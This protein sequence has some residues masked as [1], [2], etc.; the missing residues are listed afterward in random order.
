MGVRHCSA[1][2][3]QNNSRKHPKMH[4]FRFPKNEERCKKWIQNSRRAD[5]KGK[6]PSYCYGNL[7]LCETHFEASMFYNSLSK[8]SLL[9][10]AIPTLFDVPNPPPKLSLK[11][12]LPIRHDLTPQ[13]SKRDKN[14]FEMTLKYIQLRRQTSKVGRKPFYSKSKE[15][16]ILRRAMEAKKQAIR[17]LRRKQEKKKESSLSSAELVNEASKYLSGTEIAVLSY[18]LSRKKRSSNTFK[19]LALSL[20]YKSSSCYKLLSKRLQFPNPRTLNRWISHYKVREGFDLQLLNSLQVK[21]QSLPEENRVCTLL[22]DEMSLK[23]NSQYD[24]YVDKIVGICLENDKIVF[25]STATV[26]M[27]S[28]VKMKW[29]QAIG[30]FFTGKGMLGKDLKE[31]IVHCIELLQDI[32]LHI[33]AITS[34]QG[35]N[36]SSAIS[37]LK[38]TE[39]QPHFD[40]NNHQIFVLN[41]PPHLWKSIRNCLLTDD[42]LTDEGRVSWVIIK[43]LYDLEKG[44]TLRMCPKLTDSHILPPKFGGKMKVRLA[45]QVF[46]HSVCAGLRSYVALQS[47]PKSALITATFCEKVNRLI[48]IMNSSLQFGSTPFKSALKLNSESF[49]EIE[50]LK[51]WVLRWK[52]VNSKGQ[53]RNRQFR[54]LRGIIMSLNS[55]KLICISVSQKYNL[56]YIMTRRLCQDPLEHFF[57]LIRQK[58]GFNYN[59]TCSGFKQAFRLANLN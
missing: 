42:I 48:D 44:K 51:E 23:Q 12:K 47:L 45:T 40:V 10:N 36:F 27:V 17:V 25:P 20:S 46:S 57:S 3:C 26:F 33:I 13:V 8:S 38:V 7:L 55:L 22:I 24:R 58:G 19:H 29:R 21:I 16:L 43:Q 14:M 52:V 9:R 49:I 11:R 32:G 37:L 39:D 53:V 31:K 15:V 6:S 56:S 59:P 30:Y 1:I 54:F 5:L 34:D 35:S 50:Q 2:N 18:Q 4:F 41:D 28:G